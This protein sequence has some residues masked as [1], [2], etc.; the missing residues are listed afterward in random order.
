V[1]SHLRNAAEKLD[2]QG[3]AATVAEALR[4]GLVK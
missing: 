4:R 3:K 2:V 1:K